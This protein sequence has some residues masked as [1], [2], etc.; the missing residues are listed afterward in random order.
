MA[1]GVGPGPGRDRDETGSITKNKSC[2]KL[3]AYWS[4]QV[5]DVVDRGAI[6]GRYAR[7]P[8]GS[9]QWLSGLAK[10]DAC[11]P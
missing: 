4:V 11:F 8:A 6:G 5:V 9:G 1:M 7:P 10:T 3:F 2:G